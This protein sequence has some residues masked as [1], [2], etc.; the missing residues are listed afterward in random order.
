[1]AEAISEETDPD[2]IENAGVGVKIPSA[3]IS[4]ISSRI[5]IISAEGGTAA[6]VY[7]RKLT[8]ALV[9]FGCVSVSWLILMAA[10]IGIAPQHTGLTWY[11][12]ALVVAGL[13]LVVAVIA[14]LMAM[15]RTAP[16]FTVT[17]SEFKKDKS[18]INS[19]KNTQTSQR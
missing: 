14:I 12:A 9:A 1:M 7:L 2:K 4:L 13:H 11:Q 5:A 6:E 10:V 16:L 15:K 19:V 18:W 3:I 8:C 17:L